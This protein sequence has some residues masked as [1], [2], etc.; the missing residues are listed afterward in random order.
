MFLIFL[1]LPPSQST[2]MQV[3]FC[4]GHCLSSRQDNLC[5]NNHRSSRGC[6]CC[7]TRTL[8]VLL[9]D[10][11]CQHGSKLVQCHF[12]HHFT[13]LQ[14][15]LKYAH[16]SSHI[17]GYSRFPAKAPGLASPPGNRLT[18]TTVAFLPAKASSVLQAWLRI[19]ISNTILLCMYLAM[20]RTVC[21]HSFQTAF[22][23]LWL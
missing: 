9:G 23:I 3:F 17:K 22:L 15:L 8:P 14:M 20:C 18:T 21:L 4:K 2:N 1:R 5:A 7:C 11:S 6:V 19:T 16:I 13:S 10:D 12:V